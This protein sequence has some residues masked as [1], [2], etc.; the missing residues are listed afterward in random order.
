MAVSKTLLLAGIPIAYR[1][2]YK[3]TASFYADYFPDLPALT[4]TCIGPDG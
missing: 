1:F 3:E 2:R 4:G